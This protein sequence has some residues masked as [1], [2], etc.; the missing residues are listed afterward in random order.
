[1]ANIFVNA[2][3]AARSWFNPA[4]ADVGAAQPQVPPMGAF[5]DPLGAARAAAYQ[6]EPVHAKSDGWLPSWRF[7]QPPGVGDAPQHVWATFSLY[8]L[9][10]RG[11]GD[12]PVTYLRI[13]GPPI[14]ANAALRYQGMAVEGGNFLLTGLY[15]P[16]PLESMSSGVYSGS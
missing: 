7:K 8:P 16:A 13:G 4:A 6:T 15:T 2:V 14:V 9:D 12:N 11:P 5:N 1:L 10:I 3:A